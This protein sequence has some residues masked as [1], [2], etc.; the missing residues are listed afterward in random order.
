MQS[1]KEVT[2]DACCTIS[3]RQFISDT[4]ILHVNCEILLIVTF[5]F[6]PEFYFSD[7]RTNVYNFVGSIYS[8]CFLDY[9]NNGESS[10]RKCLKFKEI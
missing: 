10:T 2:S 1:T 9:K 3:L 6:S 8:F 7:M 4:I 5:F